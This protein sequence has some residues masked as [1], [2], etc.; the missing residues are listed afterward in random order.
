MPSIAPPKRIASPL[1]IPEISPP[2]IAQRNKSSLASGEK[3]ATS[4]GKTSV[5]SQADK[6]YTATTKTE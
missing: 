2:K 6:E 5:I 3:L 1:P 4:I